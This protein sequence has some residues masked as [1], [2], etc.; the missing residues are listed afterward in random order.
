MYR[1]NMEMP[2]TQEMSSTQEML[3]TQEMSSTLFGPEYI[4]IYKYINVAIERYRYLWMWPLFSHFWGKQA[5]N[6]NT[7]YISECLRYLESKHSLPRVA[8]IPP[9]LLSERR[10]KVTHISNIGNC[11]KYWFI[12]LEDLSSMAG[13]CVV[14]KGLLGHKQ[15]YQGINY[16]L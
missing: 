14:S 16:K 5:F 11:T 2:S 12:P 15:D 10:N 4:S 7:F 1:C 13:R 9:K 3:S 8:E 6:N